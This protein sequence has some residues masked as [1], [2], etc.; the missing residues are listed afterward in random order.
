M[1][2]MI[3]NP[4]PSLN[5]DGGIYRPT[6]ISFDLASIKFCIYSLNE[7]VSIQVLV[8]NAKIR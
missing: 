8:R 7:L 5:K 1:H 3:M 4:M 2:I 6:V